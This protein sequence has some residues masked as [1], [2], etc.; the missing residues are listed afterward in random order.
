MPWMIL[1]LLLPFVQKYAAQ[2]VADY[3]ENRREQRLKE[4]E[5]AAE[6]PPCPPCPTDAPAAS[7]RSRRIW[8][9]LSG[10]LLGS[11]FGLI[12]YLLVRQE[13]GTSGE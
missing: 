11:A 5:L 10:L 3:L 7:T 13:N 1:R 4:A 9:S 6:C 8:Y 2:Y 12:G